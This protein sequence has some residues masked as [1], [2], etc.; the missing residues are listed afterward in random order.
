[1]NPVRILT[2]SE[3]VAEHLRKEL[4]QGTWSG[5]MPGSN[6]LARELGVGGNTLEA[7]LG[8]LESE[9]IL[10]SQGPGRRRKI[11]FLRDTERKQLR[12]AILHYDR[13]ARTEGYLL[14]LQHA[15]EAAGHSIVPFS[16]T[17]EDLKMDLK[18]VST[19]VAESS[20]DAWVLVAAS[21]E[22]LNWFVEE[23]VRAFAL[24]G[25]RRGLVLAGAGPD[26]VPAYCAAVRRLH[27]NGH[28]RIVLLTSKMRRLPLPGLPEQAFLDELRALSLPSG[29]YNLP[30]WESTPKGLHKILDSLFGM[31]PPTALIVDEAPHFIAAQQYLARRGVFAPEKISLVCTDYHPMFAWCFPSIAH[32]LWDHRALVRRI[33]RWANNLSEGKEDLRQTSTKAKFVEGGTVGPVA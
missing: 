1:M 20:V 25:R 8:Q 22:I 18:S 16:H 21:R 19:L 33:V 23:K 30:D 4:S 24:F 9:G 14:D 28:R 5:L 7:A 3:Q 32:I 31:T 10:V 27:E 17:F 15:V 2:A 6:R 13:S 26:K 12:I 29:L 11:L